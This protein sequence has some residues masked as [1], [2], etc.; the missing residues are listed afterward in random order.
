MTSIDLSPPS[1]D[2]DVIIDI[3]SS[4]TE[5][6]DRE[7][8]KLKFRL[9]LIDDVDNK[10]TSEIKAKSDQIRKL[11]CQRINR[12]TVVAHGVTKTHLAQWW[13]S[14]GF[15]KETIS[16]E[17]FTVSN[18]VSCIHCFTTYRYGSSSTE[19]IAHHECSGPTT[20]NSSTLDKHFTKQKNPFRLCE[21]RHLTKLFTNWICDDL[22]PISVVEDSGLKKICSYFYSL[23]E[24]NCSRS[25]DLDSLF[26][27]RQTISR[28]LKNEAQL[29][30][31]QISEL[32]KEPVE[33]QALTAAPDIWTDRYRQ[34]S[35]L[36]VTVT[37][38]DLSQQFKKLTLCC[39]NFPVDLAKTGENISK[40]LKEELNRYGIEKIDHIN[41]ISDRGSN[42][43]KCFNLNSIDPIFCFAHRIHNVLTMTFINKKIDSYFNDD[44]MDD[45]PDNLGHEEFLGDELLTLVQLGTDGT[46]TLKQSV[47]TRWLSLFVCAESVYCNFDAILLA[48][49]TRRT[50]RY[51][52]DLTKYN[53]ID[54]L[55]LLAPLNAALHAIQ[56]DQ[57]PSLHLVIPFYQKLLHDY[58]THSKLVSSSK[59]KY[60]SIFQSSFVADY[61]LNESSGVRFFRQRIRTKLI[62]MLTFDD[63]HYMAMCL[64]PALREMDGVSNQLKDVCYDN[65]RKYLR[66]KKVDVVNTTKDCNIPTN[67]RRKLLHKFLDEDGDNEHDETQIQTSFDETIIDRN[68][69]DINLTQNTGIGRRRSSSS[70][71]LSTEFSYST[72]YQASKPDEL[73]EYLEADI[74]SSIV[75]D[76]P[77]HFWSSV[78]QEAVQ[79][80]IFT[81]IL[82]ALK[83][84][85]KIKQSSSINDDNMNKLACTFI[86]QILSHQNPILYYAA[87][88]T[89]GHLTQVIGDGHFVADIVPICFDRL[90]EFCVVSSRTDYSLAFECSHRYIALTLDFLLSISLSQFHVSQCYGHLLNALTIKINPKLQTNTNYISILRSSCLTTSNLLQIYIESIVQAEVIQALQQLHLFDSCHVNLST[91][92]SELIKTLKSQDL[93]LR[94]AYVS[95]LRQ[96]S[97]RKVK[98]IIKHTKLFMKDTGQDLSMGLSEF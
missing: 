88:E 59:K 25:M 63:R 35:Y 1:T 32:I 7:Q 90:K 87:D 72:T 3:S 84:L 19:S 68:R 45:I 14:F 9:A 69:E 92:V 95:C 64:H 96:L 17:T 12:F 58:S 20:E 34:L 30:R 81:A 75:K 27:S 29:Y 15:A 61:L 8:L 6:I 37:F 41:W 80:N 31:E 53:L 44:S 2:D 82:I 48:L 40:I 13:S 76:N 97:Q 47:V 21:Q 22:R 62:E 28:S 79:V 24:K 54:L 85:T 16:G 23:G 43:I 39:R 65:I 78:R 46:T 49:E 86:M 51:V 50:T 70:S 56:T 74:P 73:D 42:F 36:G 4:T 93:S 89:L 71:S 60:P 94:R 66:E 98:E 26:Q 91:V 67:K 55:L 11:L 10:K 52:N 5:E 83:T 77:L 33:N 57:T 18:F 38:I